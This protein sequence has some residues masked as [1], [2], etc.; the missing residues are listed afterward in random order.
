MDDKEQVISRLKIEFR[1]WE[2]LLNG[3]SEEQSTTSYF[4]NGRS[5]KDIV[6]HLTAWQQVTIA[7]LNA[8]LIQSEPIL[9]DW[10]KGLDPELEEN[11]DSYNENIFLLYR[12]MTW[13]SI[14][15][16]WKERYLKILELAEVIPA[17]DMMDPQKYP[18]L[19]GYPL[20]AILQGTH[21]HHEEHYEPLLVW[22]LQFGD[23]N[24]ALEE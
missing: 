5:I 20:I 11:I 22:L 12:N 2:K 4:D 24:V 21:E 16:E 17:E 3:G 9:P 10:L 1:L 18:W 14:H 19:K 13:S 7:R 23:G 15:E 6:A 8:A